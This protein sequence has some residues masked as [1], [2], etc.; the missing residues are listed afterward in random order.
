MIIGPEWKFDP[1][2][3]RII[4]AGWRI[5]V[6]LLEKSLTTKEPLSKA[7]RDWLLRE[8][9]VNSYKT[10]E[11]EWRS[12]DCTF[13]GRINRSS[14]VIM[15]MAICY[16]LGHLPNPIGYVSLDSFEATYEKQMSGAVSAPMTITMSPHTQSGLGPTWGY[17]DDYMHRKERAVS[18]KSVEP[19]PPRPECFGEWS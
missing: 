16:P 15:E 18:G 3:E 17:A 13:R 5:A 7:E 10:G 9:K 2:F 6:D 19:P 8:F 11:A 1:Q 4:V 14:Q 12:I